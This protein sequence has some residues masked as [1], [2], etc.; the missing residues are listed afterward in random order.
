MSCGCAST[1]CNCS[2]IAPP[3][4][5]TSDSSDCGD[6]GAFPGVYTLCDLD[7]RNNVWVAGSDPEGNGGICMLDTMEEY[8][9]INSLQRSVKAKEDLLKVTSNSYLRDLAERV[10]QYPTTNEGDEAQTDLNKNTIPFYSVF[11]GQPPFAQ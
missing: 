6:P 9:I 3:V 8:Q 10:P 2:N 5:D 4:C 1:P 11:R 7:R